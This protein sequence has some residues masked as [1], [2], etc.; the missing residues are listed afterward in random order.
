MKKGIL[1][2]VF[3][4]CWSSLASSKFNY[5]ERR[6]FAEY[7]PQIATLVFNDESEEF[8]G[9]LEENNMQLSLLCEAITNLKDHKPKALVIGF[10]LD[11]DR[12]DGFCIIDAAIDN[13]IPIIVSDLYKGMRSYYPQDA[14]MNYVKYGYYGLQLF[15]R[16]VDGAPDQ[17]I[18]V[19]YVSPGAGVHEEIPAFL[20]ALLV[21]LDRG[22]LQNIDANLPRNLT[23]GDLTEEGIRK[24]TYQDI[25]IKKTEELE[26]LEDK[27]VFVG[28]DQDKHARFL[29][30]E[31]QPV[32]DAFIHAQLLAAY[33]YVTNTTERG[34]TTK[35]YIFVDH[36]PA[37]VAD[38]GIKNF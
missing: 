12:D 26:A 32:N 6:N 22:R 5:S 28:S 30:N 21:G 15:N 1:V 3:F 8:F 2:V 13:K 10:N 19:E 11:N 38:M 37:E 16:F 14:F 27:Y 20:R 4:F 29:G 24:V 7:L 9:N 31:G 18:R 33:L 17:T 35:P 25:L 36:L 34:S 23:I